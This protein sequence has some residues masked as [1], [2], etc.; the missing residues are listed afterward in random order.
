MTLF[1]V[2][3]RHNRTNI[4]SIVSGRP[5][6]TRNREEAILKA[7]LELFGERGFY[8]TT[9]PSVVERA[10]IAAGT[11]YHYFES[12]E[13]LVNVVYRRW[14]SEVARLILTDFPAD[15]P[16]REQF[17][18]TWERMTEFALAHPKELAFL[19]LHQHGSYLD[20]ESQ[21]IE[22][23]TLDFGV[24]MLQRAQAAQALKPMDPA[25]L[26]AIVNGAFIGIVRQGI[27]KRVALTRETLMAAEVCC[28]EAIR[29]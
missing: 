28:W 15:H 27:E 22:N 29:A 6:D 11:F 8:G 9:V 25:V 1:P 24:M 4:H 2:D 3:K 5:T 18:V 26:M 21:A 23:Q 12:K 17:R 14:K 7:A 19:E 13:Q 20:S 10:E 16:P